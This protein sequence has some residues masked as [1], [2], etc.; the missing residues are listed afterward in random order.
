MKHVAAVVMGFLA[1]GIVYLVSK[2]LPSPL[3]VLLLIAAWIAS[4]LLLQK[5]A[6]TTAQVLSRGFLLGA[7]EWGLILVVA[8]AYALTDAPDH[9]TG[10]VVKGIFMIGMAALCLVGFAAVKFWQR[11]KSIPSADPH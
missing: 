4:S 3:P 6:K 5:G 1:G 9:L 11:I 8:V 10:T 7:A 2:L